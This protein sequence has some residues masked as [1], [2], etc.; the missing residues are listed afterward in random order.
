MSYR[1]WMILKLTF[2]E[3]SLWAPIKSL[4]RNPFEHQGIMSESWFQDHSTPKYQEVIENVIQNMLIRLNKWIESEGDW[5]EYQ[6]H[7]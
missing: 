5:I 3:S 4:E 2:N 6:N 7:L 1:C